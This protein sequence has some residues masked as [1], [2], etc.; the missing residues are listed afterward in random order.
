MPGCELCIQFTKDPRSQLFLVAAL[1]AK[2]LGC[3]AQ[4]APSSDLNFHVER[5]EAPVFQKKKTKPI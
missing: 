1:P 5:S 3:D 4:V 2:A